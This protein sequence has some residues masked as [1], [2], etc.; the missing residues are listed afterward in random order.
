M[1]PKILGF[2]LPVFFNSSV[3]LEEKPNTSLDQEE[4]LEC[5]AYNL[6]FT[7]DKKGILLPKCGDKIPCAMHRQAVLVEI[8]FPFMQI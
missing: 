1:Y 2:K 7:A 5:S 6:E 3:D 8:S 4:N